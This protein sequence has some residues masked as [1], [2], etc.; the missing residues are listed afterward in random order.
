MLQREAAE[1]LAADGRALEV[2]GDA[3]QYALADPAAVLRILLVLL[4]NACAYGAGTVRIDIGRE[5]ECAIVRITDEGRGLSV[6]DRGHVFERFERGEASGA[7]PGFGLGLAIA[8]G[9]AEGM[10][11][12]LEAPLVERGGCFEL[13]LPPWDDQ[14][15]KHRR[16]ECGE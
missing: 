3:P 15:A 5:D 4:D 10:G 8:R 14:P 6:A 2:S 7:H 16:E 11:G 13:R 12:G 9:L 1:R